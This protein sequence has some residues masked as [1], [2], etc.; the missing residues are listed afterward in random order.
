MSDVEPSTG[1]QRVHH[2][3]ALIVDATVVERTGA[4]IEGLQC[5]VILQQQRRVDRFMRSTQNGFGHLVDGFDLGQH[6]HCR[7]ATVDFFGSG[8]VA[9]D[10][11]GHAVVA[12][13]ADHVAVVEVHI[14]GEPR[15]AAV[16]FSVA[17]DLIAWTHSVQEV[18]R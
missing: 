5:T 10:G 15:H 18:E 2:L 8:D 7:A 14:A 9:A 6:R 3:L 12:A 1:L 11:V 13:L 17:V 4:Q 16:V